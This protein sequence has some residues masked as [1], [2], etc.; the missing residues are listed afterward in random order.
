MEINKL[1][2]KP[3]KVHVEF[4]YMLLRHLQYSIKD[5]ESYDELTEEEKKIFPKD[6]FNKLIKG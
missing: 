2:F 3:I 4:Y 6:L 1:L 5:I